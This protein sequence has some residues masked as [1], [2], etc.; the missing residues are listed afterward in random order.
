[1]DTVFFEIDPKYEGWHFHFD[2]EPEFPGGEKALINYISEKTNYPKSAIRDSVSGLVALVFCID[3]D[4]STKNFK[5]YKSVS[6]DIDNECI[7][8]VKEMPK[9]K[10]G[11]NVFR[12]KKGLYRKKV[13]VYY[14]IPFNFMLGDV[15]AKRGIVIKPK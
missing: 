15:G 9:W 14:V 4:G 12:A 2:E 1:M 3:I 8:V 5:V 6:N 10:P 11:S 7:R 13:P